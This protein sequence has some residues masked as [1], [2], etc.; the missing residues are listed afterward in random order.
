MESLPITKPLSIY[1]YTK[2]FLKNFQ[3]D[4]QF[5]FR[6]LV[7]LYREDISLLYNTNDDNRIY[8]I[9]NIHGT[10]HIEVIFGAKIFEP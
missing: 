6:I 8:H 5:S 2:S 10:S 4:V 9:W 3:N 1:S 7:M